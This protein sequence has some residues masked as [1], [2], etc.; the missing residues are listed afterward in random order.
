MLIAPPHPRDSQ[1]T[2]HKESLPE[3]KTV[4]AE[5]YKGVMDRLL[6]RIR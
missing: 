5:L 3:G 1:D 6:K 2:V 4:N